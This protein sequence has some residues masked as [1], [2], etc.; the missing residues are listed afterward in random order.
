MPTEFKLTEN[1]QRIWDSTEE[2]PNY[3]RAAFEA[4][5]GNISMEQQARQWEY[6]RK[7]VEFSNKLYGN[8]QKIKE[9]KRL[10]ELAQEQFEKLNSDGIQQLK[11]E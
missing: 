11:L 9:R 2:I 4:G 5:Y 7:D 3:A 6:A 1:Q 8:I 10:S